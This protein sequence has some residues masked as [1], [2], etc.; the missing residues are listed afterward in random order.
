MLEVLVNLAEPKH[1]QTADAKTMVV[2]ALDL[3]LQRVAKQSLKRRASAWPLEG[4]C[5]S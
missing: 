5:G 2:V 4:V 1:C 3:R